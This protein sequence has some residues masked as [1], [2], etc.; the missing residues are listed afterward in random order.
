VKAR[1]ALFFTATF[2][3]AARAEAFCADA[4][5]RDLGA[6]ARIGF[7]PAGFGSLP[8][9]CPAS[10]V[11]LQGDA[12]LLVATED[13]YGT[14]A[15]GGAI[16]GR[17]ALG[18]GT[19][20]SAWAPGPAFLYVANATVEHS[21]VDLGPSS[22][23]LHTSVPFSP[24]IRFAPFVRTLL[25]TETIYHHAVRYGV[26]HGFTFGWHGHPKIEVYSGATFPLLLTDGS[27]TVHPSF[28]PSFRA[29]A[30]YTP[31]RFFR[32]NAGFSF[33]FRGGDDNAFEAFEPLLALRFL[34]VQKLR[35]ELATRLPLAGADRT[36]A[37]VSLSA[38][39]EFSRPEE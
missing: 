11:G 7:G 39:W 32:V 12:A 34:P 18:R 1:S 14:V 23:G 10:E 37:G 20:V 29:E 22:L 9:V 15:A 36:D 28:G 4:S 13:F 2:F 26:E 3:A 6:P 16:R 30:A 27:G 21:S 17:Y 8:E 5:A 31:F 33:R 38:A 35:I 25:P 19:W 24:T